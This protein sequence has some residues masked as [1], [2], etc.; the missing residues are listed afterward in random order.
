MDEHTAVTPQSCIMFATADWDDPYWTNKQHCAKSLAELGT[1][2]LYVESV[3]IRRPRVSSIKDWRRMLRRLFKGT[4][5]LLFGAKE[6]APGIFVLSPLLV[7]SGHR[8]AFTDAINRWLLKRTIIR[9]AKSYN[10]VCPLIWTY[11]PF[12]LDVLNSLKTGPLLYHCVDD[13]ATVPGVNATVFRDAEVELLN[14]SDIVF[15]TSKNLADYCKKHNSNTYFFSNV[16]DAEHFGKALQLGPIPSDLSCIPEPRLC[17]HG[18]LSDFKIDFKLLIEAARQKPEWSWIFIGQE[19]EGQRSPL[20]VELAKLPNVHFLGYR[21]YSLLPD[22]LRGVQVGILP[23]L[24]NDYTRGMFPMK[25]FEY[26]ASGLPTVSTPIAFSAGCNSGLIVAEDVTAFNS[27]IQVQLSR[28]KFSSAEVI[29]LIGDNT[30]RDR[31][32]KM[33]SLIRWTA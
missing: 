14:C 12:I 18:V 3:G 19:R 11:H 21:S 1:L 26:L 5:S 8:Y 23:S 33:L 10:F 25:Y 2:V 31:L 15:T 9:N 27:A 7:P 6:C 16:V 29:G 28:G 20:V 13:L 30:W 24:I 32:N 4:Y 22:Y 17:Y